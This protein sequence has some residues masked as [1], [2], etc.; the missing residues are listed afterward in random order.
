VKI[1]FTR[2]ITAKAFNV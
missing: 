1:Q 2:C